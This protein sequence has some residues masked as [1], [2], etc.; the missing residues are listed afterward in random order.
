MSS[1]LLNKPLNHSSE[2]SLSQAPETRYTTTPVPLAYGPQFGP[3][4]VAVVRVEETPAGECF[5]IGVSLCLKRISK[6]R[7]TCLRLLEMVVQRYCPPPP[8]AGL[9][10]FVGPAGLSSHAEKTLEPL[11]L[12][13]HAQTDPAGRFFAAGTLS[14]SDCYPVGPVGPDATGGPVGPDVYITDP[15]SL[16]H[17]ARTPPDPD[18]QDAAATGTPSPSDCYTAGPVWFM[19][20]GTLLAQMTVYLFWNHASTWFQTM[21]TQLVSLTPSRILRN[22]YNMRWL[23]C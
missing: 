14:P 20:Q 4:R 3:W 7:L 10:N 13:V 9:M 5:W 18:G 11:Q 21:L 23:S 19:S 2:L 17:V 16:K 8:R 6:G 1:D 22:H 12:M 15:N